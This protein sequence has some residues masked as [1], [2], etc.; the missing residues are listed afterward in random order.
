MREFG[1]LLFRPWEFCA[2][3]ANYLTGTK[4]LSVDWSF[5]ARTFLSLS[6]DESETERTRNNGAKRNCA[7]AHYM[8]LVCA[9]GTGA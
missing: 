5:A 8:P 3:M 7:H 6:N 1:T 9:V 4:V 2:Y